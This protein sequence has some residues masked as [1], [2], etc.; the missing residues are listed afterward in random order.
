MEQL[1]EKTEQV[2]NIIKNYDYENSNLMEITCLLIYSRKSINNFQKKLVWN[3]MNELVEKLENYLL[4]N[5][6]LIKKTDLDEEKSKIYMKE[7]DISYQMYIEKLWNY[8][9]KIYSLELDNIY[10]EL[11]KKIEECKTTPDNE[12]LEICKELHNKLRKYGLMIKSLDLIKL[13]D[14]LYVLDEL[15]DIF[16]LICNFYS[17]H[18]NRDQINDLYE[19]AKENKIEYLIFDIINDKIK[20]NIDDKK[21]EL[22]KN[23]SEE[24]INQ[25]FYEDLQ[26]IGKDNLLE[27]YENLKNNINIDLFVKNYMRNTKK[28]IFDEVDEINKYCDKSITESTFLLLNILGE[29]KINYLNDFMPKLIDLNNEFEDEIKKFIEKYYIED[30]KYYIEDEEYSD[31]IVIQNMN[32][33]EKILLSIKIKNILFRVKEKLD[34]KFL[35]LCENIIQ[36]NRLEFSEIT[37]KFMIDTFMSIKDNTYL[38]FNINKIKLN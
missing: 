30:E 25:S 19:N 28:N 26:K 16:S 35:E 5:F 36:K 32:L 23:N 20:S 24:L 6:D 27:R 17:E 10:I 38:S 18:I 9:V 13:M 14:Y 12:K 8:Y 3:I 2:L 37:K 11:N 4:F 34:N 33:E 22:I 7:P 31:N 29:E 21:I 1:I 15:S